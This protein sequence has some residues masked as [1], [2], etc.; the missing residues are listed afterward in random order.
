MSEEGCVEKRES[1]GG[2]VLRDLEQT[3][4]RAQKTA[5]VVG[6]RTNGVTR[7]ETKVQEGKDIPNPSYPPFFEQIR[8]KTLSINESLSQIEDVMRRVEL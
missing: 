8:Q 4:E 3:A 1:V 6:E 5:C 2:Q 7:S